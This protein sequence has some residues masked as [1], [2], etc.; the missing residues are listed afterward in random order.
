MFVGCRRKKKIQMNDRLRWNPHSDPVSSQYPAR[1]W[2]GV[3]Y[4]EESASTF[5]PSRFLSSISNIYIE[6]LHDGI[7]PASAGN[8]FRSWADAR[9]S[10][11]RACGLLG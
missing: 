7:A 10:D 4:P 3:D 8:L 9:P 11:Q 1:P 2:M 6:C 5:H